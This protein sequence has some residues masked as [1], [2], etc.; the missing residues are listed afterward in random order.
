DGH[1]VPYSYNL[2]IGRTAPQLGDFF[3]GRI[4]EVRVW[5]FAR[6]QGDLQSQMRFPLSGQEPGLVGYWPLHDGTGSSASDGTG[7]GYNGSLAGS[8]TP[9]WQS[10]SDQPVPVTLVCSLPV[11]NLQPGT[12]YSCCVVV[13]NAGGV[14]IG[15]TVSFTTAAAPLA[16]PPL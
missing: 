16:T 14:L 9:T 5:N 2:T 8:T 1:S 7:H 12:N 6:S 13:S 3:Q 10:A 15:N 11:A 4:N